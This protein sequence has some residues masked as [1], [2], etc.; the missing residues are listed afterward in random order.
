MQVTPADARIVT[1]KICT[2]QHLLLKSKE[3]ILDGILS[4][5]LNVTF[6]VGSIK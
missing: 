3:M 2:I 6:L 4:D 1:F 5:D